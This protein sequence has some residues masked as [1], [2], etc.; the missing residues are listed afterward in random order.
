MT[1]RQMIEGIAAL[2]GRKPTMIEFPVLTPYL[3]SLC[4]NLVTR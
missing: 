1:Y 2:P 4:L 3:S